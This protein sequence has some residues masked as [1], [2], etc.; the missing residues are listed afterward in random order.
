MGVSTSRENG[1]RSS[2]GG[3]HWLYEVIPSAIQSSAACNRRWATDGGSGVDSGLR[4]GCPR[5]RRKVLIATWWSHTNVLP[6]DEI[7]A[8]VVN[9]CDCTSVGGTL[10][11]RPGMHTRVPGNQFLIVSPCGICYS[12]A[13]VSALDHVGHARNWKTKLLPAQEI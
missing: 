11:V 6:G 13:G 2:Y 4:D 5:D 10:Q 1:H 8:V 12:H 7:G 9:C 3:T